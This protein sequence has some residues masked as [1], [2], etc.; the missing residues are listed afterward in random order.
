MMGTES[1]TRQLKQLLP[2]G[3]VWEIDPEGWVYR[4]LQAIADEFAR[5]DARGEDL[6]NETDPRTALETL[7]DW[8]AMLGLT[9]AGS[10]SER[11][12]AVAVKYTARGGQSRQFYID[13]A[14]TLGYTITIDE[15]RVL[16]SGFRSGD[17][18]IGDDWAYTW[19]VNIV[20]VTAGSVTEFRSG[21]AR[22]GDRIR[23]FES[24]DIEDVIR[25]AAPA[26]TIVLFAYEE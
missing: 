18:C 10:V 13:L 26:H 20:G 24:L 21:T 12:T 14:A 11:Q 4:V 2:P 16:R 25:R 3:D 5:V 1:Y 15:H 7:A 8:E 19:I 17:R 23:G 9:A 22:S 6:I